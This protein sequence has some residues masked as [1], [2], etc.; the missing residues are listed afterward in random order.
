MSQEYLPSRLGLASGV[1]L[2]LA[3]GVGGIAAAGLG[4]V[5]DA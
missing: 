1:S 4:V 2:G 3:I 5:A